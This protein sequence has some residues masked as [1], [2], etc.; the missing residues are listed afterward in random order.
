MGATKLVGAIP[1]EPYAR[2]DSPQTVPIEH[3]PETC[4]EGVPELIEPPTEGIQESPQQKDENVDSS[5][6]DWDGPN[7]PANPMNWSPKF[8]GANCIIISFYTFI[9]YATSIFCWY[10]FL[11]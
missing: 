6:V 5:L 4:P 7:D 3:G 10:V 8:K 11:V 1:K 9:T 2:I